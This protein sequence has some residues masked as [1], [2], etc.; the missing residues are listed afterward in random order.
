VRRLGELE[1]AVMDRLWSW[2]RPASVREVLDELNRKRDLAYTTVMTVM[3]NLYRKGLLARERDG[4]A[5]LY[6]P[7]ASREE[8]TAELMEAALATGGDRTAALQRFVNRMDPAEAAA[9]R[10]ALDAATRRRKG[11]RR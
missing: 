7:T 5:Y 6:R 9:L 10:K 4:R 1:A 2:N 8:H 11:T 3:D